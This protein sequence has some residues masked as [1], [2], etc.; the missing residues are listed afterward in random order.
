MISF[1]FFIIYYVEYV[2]LILM[3]L[4]KKKKKKKNAYIKKKS[5]IFIKID[6]LCNFINVRIQKYCEKIYRI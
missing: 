5:N 3:H 2:Y 1:S 4:Y 6:Y